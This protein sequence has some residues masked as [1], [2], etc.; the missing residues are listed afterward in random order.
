MFYDT[1]VVIFWPVKDVA[2]RARARKVQ[3]RKPGTPTRMEVRRDW[4]K[5]AKI[6]AQMATLT[7]SV[8]MTVVTVARDLPKKIATRPAASP[9][10]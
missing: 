9:M 8:A 6:V 5:K 2:E 7:G 3:T 4:A 10:A 1:F